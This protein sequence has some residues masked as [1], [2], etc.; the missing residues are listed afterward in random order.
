MTYEIAFDP[1][2]GHA[3]LTH[4]GPISSEDIRAA[5]IDLIARATK[6]GFTRVLVDVSAIV[7]ELPAT[8]LFLRTEEHSRLG[9]P[10]P[11]VA[12]IGREDQERDLGF[13]ENVAVNRGMPLRA[14]VDKSLALE[15]LH[16]P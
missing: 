8:E 15:W 6:E 7:N 4:S 5:G 9:P 14:F 10:R 16:G 12:L 11:R 3:V 13:I 1:A 2:A